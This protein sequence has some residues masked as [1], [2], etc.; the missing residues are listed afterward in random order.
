VSIFLLGELFGV[1]GV[2]AA[3]VLGS[4]AEAIFLIS[5]NKFVYKLDE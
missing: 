4:S 1:N 3:L 5:V 2:A